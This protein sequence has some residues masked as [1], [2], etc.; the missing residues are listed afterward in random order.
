MNLKI[1][2]LSSKS[3]ILK[4]I[5]CQ[6]NFYK[7]DKYFV[8]PLIADRLKLLDVH[9]N[10]FYKHSLIEL[11]IAES[12]G[13]IVGR[14]AAIINENHNVTH[15]DK[16]G[17]FGFFESIDNPEVSNALLDK[18]S[19]WLKERG[20]DTIRG[21][22]NPSMNDE[23]GLLIDGYDYIPQIMMPYNP[24]YYESLI[25][26]A[27]F[28]K[29]KD[30][31]AFLVNYEMYSSEKLM[32]VQKIVRERYKVSVRAVNFKNKK[33]FLKDVEDVKEIYNRAWVPNWGFV[34]W[35]EDEFNALASDLKQVAD[36]EL[37]V[38]AEINN[39]PV[40]FAIALPN[41]NQALQYN[42][43]GS[44]VGAI[45]HLL[46]KKKKIN[47]LRIAALG[48]LPE[49]QKSGIDSILYYE[50]G[51]RG[52]KA[53][54]IWGEASWILEDNVMMVRGMTQTMSAKLYKTYRI[55][56]KKLSV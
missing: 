35:T 27:G 1:Y 23:I 14:I 8:P 19:D 37:C 13:E 10:P 30:L 5:K 26:A 42:K 28:V 45:W 2:S 36:P 18:A 51:E 11:F 52:T 31:Y 21:P 4:F 17:F 43:N 56:E 20:Y 6:W 38:I 53:G 24:K 32:R 22:V 9:K 46:T 49:Y 44:L 55:Y 15:S 41:I 34:K 40:G 3:D 47:W 12:D 7:D 39:K 48:V 16:V 50:I 29:A 54:M 25:E 33:Q